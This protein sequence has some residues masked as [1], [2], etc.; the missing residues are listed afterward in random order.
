[1]KT[2]N[3]NDTNH[4]TQWINSFWK[5]F[6]N[7]AIVILMVYFVMIVVRL[8]QMK[9]RG[10]TFTNKQ[11][12]IVVDCADYDDGLEY[13]DQLDYLNAEKC[14]L[15]ALSIVG[16]REGKA[17]VET[18]SICEQLGMLYLEMGRYEESYEM[19]NNAYVTFRQELGEDDGNT[20]L[21]KCHIS[22]Y[23]IR[24]DNVERGL[25]SLDEAFDNT[26]YYVYKNYILQLIAECHTM[27]GNYEKAYK[28]YL[29]LC[30]F[31]KQEGIDNQTGMTLYNDIGCL[32]LTVGQYQDAMTAFDHAISYWDA[33]DADEDYSIANVYLNQAKAYAALGKDKEAVNAGE[34]GCSIAKRLFGENNVYVA[35][36]YEG[37]ASVYGTMGEQ[38][39]QIDRL[40][41]ALNIARD[42]VGENHT[43]TALIY[44][45]IS[46][47][48]YEQTQFDEAIENADRSLEIRKNILGVKNSNTITTYIDLSENY[49]AKAD[50]DKSVEY[51]E[52]AMEICEEVYGRDNPNTV[53]TYVACALSY[54]K[55]NRG[56]EARKCIDTS[57]DIC[58]RYFSTSNPVY[59]SALQAAGT[60]YSFLGEDDLS[61]EYFD[62]ADIL[63]DRS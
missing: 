50:Y 54:I 20:V 45:D 31:Y 12:T 2:R 53:Q 38:D 63:N 9:N 62:K 16:K 18:A 15:N 21:A 49:L 37:L 39:K 1:M 61:K 55:V 13:W 56:D 47:Y 59:A 36:A 27:I 25:A 30:D 26:T 60:V 35:R 3:T 17:S 32:L 10:W 24:T 41:D 14:L 29:V 58:Q 40:K 57:L 11:A 4:K 6:R 19:L 5:I 23:D 42:S 43:V 33:M 28:Q 7:I 46:D 22:I 34:T 44:Q 8:V 48:C 52:K 51:A